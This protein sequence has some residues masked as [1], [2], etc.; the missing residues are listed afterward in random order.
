MASSASSGRTARTSVRIGPSSNRTYLPNGTMIGI[1]NLL[2]TLVVLAGA[3]CLRSGGDM[4]AARQR[5]GNR[6]QARQFVLVQR[7]ERNG[8]TRRAPA[9]A[10]DAADQHRAIVGGSGE[11]D[12]ALERCRQ[13]VGGA[14]EVDRRAVRRV[15]SHRQTVAAAGQ[16]LARFGQAVFGG[17]CKGVGPG[18]P[19]ISARQSTVTAA[20]VPLPVDDGG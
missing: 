16:C 10:A 3:R 4:P 7:E 1:G 8:D 2:A 11:R 12:G 6:V 17:E 19:R 18:R 13:G 9:G 15:R 14:D 20:E 5:G